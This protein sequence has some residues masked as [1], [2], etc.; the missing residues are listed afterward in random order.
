M[1]SEL[2]AKLK[3]PFWSMQLVPRAS[4][5]RSSEPSAEVGLPEPTCGSTHRKLRVPAVLVLEIQLL[6]W[7]ATD[8]PD[9]L[10]K[11]VRL[12]TTGTVSGPD[13]VCALVWVEEMPFRLARAAAA[14]EAPV[15]PAETGTVVSPASDVP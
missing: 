1:Q 10:A 14:V 7:E 6:N 2:S 13:M 5:M 12:F 3:P 4:R 11:L 8:D 9:R 15:P